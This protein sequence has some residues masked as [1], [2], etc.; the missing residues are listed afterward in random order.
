MVGAIEVVGLIALRRTGSRRREPGEISLMLANLQALLEAHA[1]IVGKEV[2]A[3]QLYIY[4]YIYLCIHDGDCRPQ[5]YA[6]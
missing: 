5:H 3:L 6:P 4:I 2:G 1:R